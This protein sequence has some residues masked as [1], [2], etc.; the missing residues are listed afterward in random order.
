MESLNKT[1]MAVLLVAVMT[2]GMA[3]AQMPSCASKLVSCASDLNS[4]KPSEGCCTSIKQAVA[5]EL[6]CL[7]NLYNTPGLL[8][9]F[10]VSVAQALQLT[11]NCGVPVKLDQCKSAVAGAPA[12]QSQPPPGVP[13]SDKNGAERTVWTGISSLFLVFVSVLLY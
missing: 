2:V 8:Q 5:T 6:S 1:I 11:Q 4:T 7:C 12:P 9:S 3:E 10:G 13:G